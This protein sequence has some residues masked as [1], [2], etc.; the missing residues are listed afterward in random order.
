MRTLYLIRH[1]MPDF[2]KGRRFCL[3]STDLP[4]GV[5]GRMQAILLAE[6]MKGRQIDACFCSDLSRSRQTA[7]CLAE[8]P[9]ILPGF[10]EMDC[11]EWEGLSFSEIQKRWPDIYEKRGSNRSYPMPG[12]EKPEQGRQRFWA[13][14]SEALASCTGDVAV[15]GHAG[16][17]KTFLCNLLGYDLGSYGEIVLDYASVTTV[18]IGETYS[19]QALNETVFPELQRELCERLLAE[20]GTPEPVRAHCRVVADRAMVLCEA[21]A[22]GGIYLDRHLV[23]MAAML[24]DIAR[25]EPNHARAGADWMRKLGYF[26][27]ADLIEK[28]HDPMCQEWNEAMVL[29]MAD[30]CVQETK[31]VSLA[32]RFTTSFPKCTSDEA[33]ARHETRYEAA[34]CMQKK[35]NEQCGKEIIL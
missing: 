16:I 15:V 14:L 8:N 12:A 35:I 11:G 10:R 22:C 26:E 28:H 29:T 5:V 1:A 17:T 32:E 4:L 23:E 19:V 2:P 6:G 34:C 31:V 7:A 21:L 25:T 13:A 27:V 3:G 24:H 20:A 9:Q 33:R 30:C 18:E